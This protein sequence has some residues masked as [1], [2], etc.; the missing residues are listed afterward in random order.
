ME[1]EMIALEKEGGARTRVIDSGD[2]FMIFPRIVDGLTEGQSTGSGSLWGS[3]SP[4]LL[5]IVLTLLDR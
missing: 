4:F 2:S 1:M 3:D 5:L